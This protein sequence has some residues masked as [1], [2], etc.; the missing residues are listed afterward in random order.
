MRTPS[1]RQR[2]YGTLACV[3]LLAGWQDAAALPQGSGDPG[4]VAAVHTFSDA[5]GRYARLRARLEEPLPSF[6]ARRDPWSVMLTRRYL[7]SEIRAARPHARQG[8][9]FAPPVAQ[10][11]R[12]VIGQAIRNAGSGGLVDKDLDVSDFLVDLAV[13]EPVPAWAILLLPEA[14]LDRLPPLPAA[15]EYRIVNGNLILWD[16]HAEIVIDALSDA[17]VVQ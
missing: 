17:F 3:W 1:N 5:I 7:A 12:R 14:L 10:V 13:N 11:F 4:Q 16:L 15:I 2:L 6:D 8:D 9:I